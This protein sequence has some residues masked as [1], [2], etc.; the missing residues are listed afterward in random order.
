MWIM[1]D[2]ETCPS[3]GWNRRRLIQSRDWD[4]TK[5]RTLRLVPIRISGDGEEIPDF[6]GVA[7]ASRI[8]EGDEDKAF[9]PLNWAE[10]DS[11]SVT[12]EYFQGGK[13]H[14]L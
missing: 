13:W 4:D 14:V 12:L 11:G 7:S 10:R 2:V 9:A 3:I 6:L 8:L 1:L 5:A